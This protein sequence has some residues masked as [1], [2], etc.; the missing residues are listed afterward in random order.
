MKKISLKKLF[1]LGLVT[2]FSVVRVNGTGYPYVTMLQGE[3]SNNVYFGKESAKTA[4]LHVGKKV[5]AL[6]ATADI[7]DVLNDPGEQRFKIALE[8]KSD[9]VSTSELALA[10][11]IEEQITDFDTANF[12]AGFALKEENAKDDEL[13]PATNKREE[14]E[15]KLATAQKALLTET[16]KTQKSNL[17]KKIASLE[18]ELALV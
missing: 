13:K 2:N 15:V 4:L 10:F 17:E 12:V 8:G 6:L 3:K 14:L 5:V 11:G 18:A 9:Y 16:R 1:A 7:V